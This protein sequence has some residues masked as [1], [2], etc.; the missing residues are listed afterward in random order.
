[1]RNITLLLAFTT[2][3]SGCASLNEKS[4]DKQTAV[5][6]QGQTVTYTVRK[7]PNFSAIT[8]GKATFALLGAVAM[9]STGNSIITTNNVADPADIIA[10]GLAKELENAY[11]VRLVTPPTSVSENDADHVTESVNGAARFVIDA[12]TIDWSFTYFPTD[13][14]HYRVMYMAKSRLIDVRTKVVVAE[15]FCKHIPDG[16]SNAPTYDELL[17]NDAARLKSELNSAASECIKSMK[18]QM[19][20]L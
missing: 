14:T 19:L 12:Q 15:G 11:A 3:L 9:I 13:W 20:P 8:A 7:K 17:A 10:A 5:E 6:I 1:M 18:A 2:T 16:N 4:I